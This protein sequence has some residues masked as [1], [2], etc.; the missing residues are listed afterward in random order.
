M[1]S[2]RVAQNNISTY[3]PLNVNTRSSPKRY[4]TI[5][6]NTVPHQ[7]MNSISDHRKG[8]ILKFSF[9]WLLFCAF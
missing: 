8:I 1:P 4:F 3:E 2:N 9:K 7:M 5:M 6:S